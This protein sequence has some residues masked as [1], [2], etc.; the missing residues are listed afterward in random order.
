MYVYVYSELIY[1]ILITDSVVMITD[2][3]PVVGWKENKYR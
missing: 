1:W 2:Y 3:V